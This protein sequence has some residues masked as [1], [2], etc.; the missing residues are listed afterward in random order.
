MRN[1]TVKNFKWTI[2]LTRK[3]KYVRV[4]DYPLKTNS[5]LSWEQFKRAF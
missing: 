3:T 5:I 2:T 1:S 4:G